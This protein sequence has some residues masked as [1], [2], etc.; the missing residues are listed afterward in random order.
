ME[1]LLCRALPRPSKQ[2]PRSVRVCQSAAAPAADGSGGQ[3]AGGAS[4]GP[5][6]HVAQQWCDAGLM[7]VEMRDDIL[8]K[9][10]RQQRMGK[11]QLATP[12]AM[13]YPLLNIGKRSRAEL[14]RVVRG[15]AA[16]NGRWTG[17][18]QTCGCPRTASEDGHE[19]PGI[20]V[21]QPQAREE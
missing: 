20:H 16:I 2:R 6:T 1:R 11:E 5:R 13:I 21:S 14:N 3:I 10:A 4:R 15:D 9:A 17:S 12:T 19:R 7:A 18:Y 8:R